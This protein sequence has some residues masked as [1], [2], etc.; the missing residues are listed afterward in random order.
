MCPLSS[1]V[2]SG[3]IGDC[4]E[5][6]LENMLAGQHGIK[7][8]NVIETRVIIRKCFPPLETTNDTIKCDAELTKFLLDC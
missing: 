4:D 3:Q 5:L 7:R 6:L 8:N 2:S 1:T